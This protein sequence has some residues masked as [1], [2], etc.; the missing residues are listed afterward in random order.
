MNIQ[1]TKVAGADGSVTEVGYFQTNCTAVLQLGNLQIES[2]KQYTIHGYA[3]A[4]VSTTMVCEGKSTNIGTGWTEFAFLI[5]PTSKMIQLAFAPGTW[6]IYNWKL[7]VGDIIT[8]WTPSPID[9]KNDIEEKSSE[10]SQTAESIRS[11]VSRV[12]N[13]LS[14][15]KAEWNQTAEGIKSN[16]SKVSSDLSTA[17]SEWNQTAEGIRTEISKKIG[18]D[19][20]KTIIDANADSIRTK[21]GTIVWEAE[22]SSMTEDG[23]F[24]CKSGHFGGDLDAAGGT[25]KGKLSAAG[26]TFSGDLSAAG[27]TF[28]GKL[29]AASGSFNGDVVADSFKTANGVVERQYPQGY[30]VNKFDRLI[31]INGWGTALTALG[32]GGFKLEKTEYY[33]ADNIGLWCVVGFNG[34][35]FKLGCLLIH[36]DGTIILYYY[37]TY[38]AGATRI[39]NNNYDNYLNYGI[40][41]YFSGSWFTNYKP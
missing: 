20:A 41:I 30:V 5:T 9:A 12:S 16:V 28:K 4:S 32:I 3:K 23:T 21:T 24:S 40:T 8:P 13:D 26:G 6:W 25:F 33:P 39:D 11:E 7:E 31:T 34:T 27:G 2:G 37:N 22:N 29:Q 38:G 1:K 19:E 36:T 14:S 10:W 17:Q 35:S 15:A 18:S